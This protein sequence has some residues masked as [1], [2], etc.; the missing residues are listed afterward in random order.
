[1]TVLAHYEM[2]VAERK[3]V[4]CHR[5]VGISAKEVKLCY[6]QKSLGGYQVCG[7]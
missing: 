6:W 7:Y 3:V 4:A 1:M 2:T 5:A